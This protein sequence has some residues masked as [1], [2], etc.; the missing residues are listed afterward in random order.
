MWKELPEDEKRPFEKTA[1]EQMEAWKEAMK[2]YVPSEDSGD[3]R[4]AKKPKSKKPSPV[5]GSYSKIPK[6]T[7]PAKAADEEELSAVTSQS[8]TA[9][10]EVSAMDA[11]DGSE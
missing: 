3:E 5:T 9:E 1:K 8:G 4:Q 2:S 6:K 10:D 7:A 11:S